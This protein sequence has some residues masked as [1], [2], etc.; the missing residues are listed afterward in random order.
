MKHL[1]TSLLIIISVTACHP[2]GGP[3]IDVRGHGYDINVGGHGN[4]GHGHHKHGKDHHKG[5]HCP[6]G[7]AKKGW[8]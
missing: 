7:H 5:Y 2:H 3:R 1:V 4:H 6:P 8:C